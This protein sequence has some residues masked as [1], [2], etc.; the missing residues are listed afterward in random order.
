[1]KSRRPSAVFFD[2]GETLVH[3]IPSFPQLFTEVCKVHGLE[4]DIAEVSLTTRKLM[5]EVEERQREGYTFTNHPQRSRRFWLSFYGRLVNELGYRGDDGLARSL[6]E[7]FSRPENYEAYPDA[8]EALEELARK[9]YRLGIISNFEPWLEDLLR[10]LGLAGYFEVMV[11]S[12]N[13]EYEKPHPRI[14][15]LALQRM[16]VSPETSLHVGDSPV[17]DFAG[18]RDAGLRAVLLDRWGR[19]PDFRGERVRDLREIISLLE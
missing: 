3:P 19:F 10:R 2:A 4:A 9:G 11:I 16:G 12:G 8:V 14:F 17:S 7:T 5:A 15:Q 18:A 6:Y 13:E 1:M